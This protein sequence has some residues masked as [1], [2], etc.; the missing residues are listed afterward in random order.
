[1]RAVIVTVR[2]WY[3]A[4]SVRERWLIMLMIGIAAPLLAWLLVVVPLDNA[5]DTALQRHLEAIDRNGRIRALADP[6]R[7][8]RST[9]APVA[10]G[11]DLQLVIAESAAQAGLTLDSNA[12]IG[13]DAVT[14][15]IAQARATA[16]VQW[17]RDFE[18]R[19]IRVEDLRMTPG[20]D[21]TV[22]VAA[23]LVRN[24]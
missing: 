24:R 12:A 22:L 17:L 6:E 20:A 16:A 5:Y 14:V 2:E 15:T 19:G 10:T 8:V 7:S 21:G 18:T 1:E 4:R 11:P 23:R 3:V 9:L 13:P